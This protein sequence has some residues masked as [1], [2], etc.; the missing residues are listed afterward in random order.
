MLKNI[1]LTCLLVMACIPVVDSVV[2]YLDRP[3]VIFHKGTPVRI[4]SPSGVHMVSK[5]DPLPEV[6]ERVDS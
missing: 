1:L 6:Y 3:V 4:E 2:Q 5:G